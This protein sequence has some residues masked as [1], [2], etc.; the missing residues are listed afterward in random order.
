MRHYDHRVHAGNAGDVWK[1]LLLLE[2]ADYLLIPDGCP[3]YAESHAGRPDYSLSMPGEWEGGIGRCWMHL[4]SLQ[5]EDFCSFAILANANPRGLEHYPGSAC[6]VLQ[7]AK[8]RGSRLQA[9]IWDI[10]PAVEAA[11][12]DCS[13]VSFHLGDG[14]SGVKSLLDRSPP[15]LPGLL[16]IDPPYLEPDDWRQAA[17]LLCRAEEKGW[18]ALCWYPSGAGILSDCGFEEHSLSFADVGLDGGRL[19]GATV[20]LAGSD[21]ALSSRLESKRQ[22]FIEAMQPIPAVVTENGE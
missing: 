20:A 4:P 21:G 17:D 9:D 19:E 13:S 15:G 12:K 10:D 1:H 2:S 7:A 14:F 18:V 16:L 8:I 6:L 11:W 22:Q 5:R 3:V